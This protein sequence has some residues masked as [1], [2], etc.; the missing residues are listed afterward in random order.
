MQTTTK[1]KEALDLIRQKGVVRPRD[2]KSHGIHPENLRRLQERGLVNQLA[3][4]VYRATDAEVTAYSSLATVAKRVPGCVICLLSAL[5]FH[6][7]TTQSPADVWIGIRSGDRVPALPGL[8]VR[9]V[10]YSP[11][12]LKVGCDAHTIEGVTI[13]VTNPGKTVADCFKYRNKIG[14]DVAIEALRECKRLRLAT[15]AQI[16]DYAKINRALNVMRPYLETLA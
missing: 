3:R 16:A 6:E 8:F 1:I 5:R 4:G 13:N 11:D 15:T 7:L 12:S 2:L 14:V 9:V 10:R